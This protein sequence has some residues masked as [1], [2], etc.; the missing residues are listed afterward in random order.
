MITIKA[1]FVLSRQVDESSD[2]IRENFSKS[3]TDEA[4]TL[5]FSIGF[6]SPFEKD[7]E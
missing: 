4:T 1:A 7:N 2:G 6:L 3:S 5:Q